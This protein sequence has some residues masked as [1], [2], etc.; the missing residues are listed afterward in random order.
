MRTATA[1]HRPAT[2]RPSRALGLACR[3][4]AC[5]ALAVVVVVSASCSP[6]TSAEDLEE[7]R[8][9]LASRMTSGGESIEALDEA[10]VTATFDGETVSGSGGCNSYSA[11]YGTDGSTIDIGPVAATLMACPEPV[12]AQEQAF[13][14]ALE[15]AAEFRVVE[16]E[17]VLLDEDGEEV[18]RFDATEPA[19][20]AGTYWV[21]TGINDGR[22]AVVSVLEGTEVTAVFDQDGEVS[23]STGCNSY[24]G[25]F[26]T[27]GD[28]LS[29]GPLAATE[30]FCEDP[31]GVMEQE[32]AFLAAMENVVVYE[33]ED[34]RL[35]LRD[36][37]GAT[38]VTL[39]AP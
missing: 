7:V 30:V 37:D 14:E 20:L 36:A 19:T 15:L 39:V 26:D 31:E 3:A 16:G 24:T 6:D 9:R 17:L 2:S 1:A 8:W 38:Q 12:M 28:A 11:S 35:T 5:A 13:F 29:I 4:A 34:D 33:L 22:E 23:G 21:A 10:P 25:P 27:D 32:Q 18:L